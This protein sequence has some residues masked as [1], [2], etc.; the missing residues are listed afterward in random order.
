M[1]DAS[2]YFSSTE[3]LLDE[4]HAAG[5][6]PD[7]RLAYRLAQRILRRWAEQLT[8]AEH[9]AYPS[10]FAKLNH[11]L[12]L[13]E[14][15]RSAR[16]SIHSARSRM[17]RANLLSLD[18][19]SRHWG[20]DVRA[21]EYL[22]RRA[23]EASATTS[24]S[25]D[26][27]PYVQEGAASSAT[28]SEPGTQMPAVL[29]IVVS[30][31]TETAV[32][33]HADNAEGTHIMAD[34]STANPYLY[35]RDW[36]YLTKLLRK[37]SQLNLV[38]PHREENEGGKSAKSPDETAHFGV[39]SVFP[40]LFIVEPDL[41]MDITSVAGCIETYAESP[42]V[43][44]V[45]RLK[46]SVTTSPIL[47]GNMASQLL[48]EML[49]GEDVTYAESARRFFRANALALTTTELSPTFHSDAQ[50]Q[51]ANMRHS[52][53]EAGM[54]PH[55]A[56]EAQ[57]SEMLIEPS[58][59]C[60]TLGL[61]GR[62]DMLQSDF[63]ILVEQKSGK[64]RWPE[65]PDPELPRQ[66]EKHYAQMLLYL[67]MLHFGFGLPNEQVSA[68]LLY[69]RYGKGLL[70]M[71]P[72]PELLHTAIRLRNQLARCEQ[73]YAEQGYGVL[74]GLTAD[75]LRL[76]PGSDRLWLQY[77]RPELEALLN[78]IQKASPL[79]RA[80]WLRL[81]HFV[82]REHYLSK[83][84][85][86]QKE[87]SGFAA[88]WHATLDEKREAGSI[89]CPLTITHIDEQMVT[90][91]ASAEAGW[92]GAFRKGD[93][94]VLYPY[95]PQSEPDIRRAATFR[96][97]I[98]DIA[99]DSITL[100]MR[101]HLPSGS[102]WAAS[103]TLALEPD[104][105]DSSSTNYLRHIHAFLSAP[106]DRRDLILCQ[107][108]PKTDETRKILGEYGDFNT[109]ATHVKQ[110]RELY[111]I[112][113]PPGT[114][115]TS[116]GLMTTL[117]EELLEPDSCILLLACTN[118]AVD[119][120]CSKLDEAELSYI[121]LTS[122]YE[123][124]ESAGETAHLVQSTR[125]FA[126]T[127]AT[128]AMHTELFTLRHF[129]LAII[130]EASQ[131]PE[132]QLLPALCGAIDR[133]VLIG[134]HKQLPAVVQ[135]SAAEAVITDPLLQA[136]GMDDCRQSFFERMLRHYRHDPSVVYMLTRQGR[137]HPDVADF[138]SQAFYEGLLQPVPLPH[139]QAASPTRR[140]EFIDA[141]LPESSPSDR[142][143]MTEARIIAEIVAREIKAGAQPAD[144]G[145]IVPYRSQGAAIGQLLR[146]M[147]LPPASPDGKV[148]ASWDDLAIDTVER[149]QG[150]QRHI[151]I[152]GFT[153]QKRHQLGFLTAN[154]FEEDGHLID[155]KLN[156]AM[157][158]AMDRLIMVGHA[159]LLRQ[160]PV[161]AQLIDALTR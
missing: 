50:K 52:L 113:G 98:H 127:T 121:R 7:L 84:G 56:D 48:D 108:H 80:Y 99:P 70:R 159:P 61:Q 151:I 36:T 51:A 81:L 148:A 120:I 87:A 85:N 117:R 1:T 60:E 109:L 41:L 141:P 130:D 23:D 44:L 146:E 114:G 4:L 66:Q 55:N 77:T 155:R 83:V 91:A 150:S 105:Y 6:Q 21:I 135:Q 95:D 156:V 64:G 38:R 19:L 103:G 26:I 33:G 88:K 40:E 79:E 96:G 134:D 147:P 93:I 89:I 18:E 11:L 158:R 69:S 154:T 57:H 45:N 8:Q 118:R 115:K 54:L 112:I 74:V 30:S 145:I 136:I 131:L 37:G 62:M 76:K 46:P 100:H 119:E 107:R 39:V 47:L 58:F 97:S 32:Y 90:L 5:Q 75:R 125:I 149:F 17:R 72:A 43:N 110:A 53:D 126:C 25:G 153:V 9:M 138:P 13:Y 3:E 142:V 157:T 42:L 143:N 82:S 161:F 67:A 14:V 63:R 129:T 59:F 94:V 20:E 22:I 86:M 104:Y 73:L 10:L 133:Y 16:H 71:G 35:G 29:R 124:P 132:P 116:F 140:V 12:N 2:S 68:Y 101:S 122:G 160:A 28:A 34:F 65:G 123:W 111:F 27:A 139:Q 49:H 31:W 128:L 24:S 144:F 102:S 15:P 92:Q 152:Y 106:Q 78:P 137:M